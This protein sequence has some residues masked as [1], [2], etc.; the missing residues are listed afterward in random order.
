MEVVGGS[1]PLGKLSFAKS[2]QTQVTKSK[3]KFGKQC[4]F[5]VEDERI[6]LGIINLNIFHYLLL[7]FRVRFSKAFSFHVFSQYSNTK[8]DKEITSQD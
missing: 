1:I 7:H 4:T 8:A 2:L 6:F 5:L 3:L